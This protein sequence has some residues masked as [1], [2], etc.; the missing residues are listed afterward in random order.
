M[1]CP[2]FIQTVEFHRIFCKHFFSCITKISKGSSYPP[3]SINALILF[4][5]LPDPAQ[6]PKTPESTYKSVSSHRAVPLSVSS[7]GNRDF[8]RIHHRK[9][10]YVSPWQMAVFSSVCEMST[11]DQIN[12]RPLLF[13][14]ISFLRLR[15]ILPRAAMRHAGNHIDIFILLD[16]FY[17]LLKQP[18]L[19]L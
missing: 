8:F 16:F 19:D 10:T 17:G 2:H 3:V 5:R 9:T 4:L 7:T 18:P 14:R 15:L 1:L 12:I 11:D 13:A 6:H